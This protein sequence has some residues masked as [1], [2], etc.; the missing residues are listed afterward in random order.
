M[1]RRG[2]TLVVLVMLVA[3]C[4]ESS[5]APPQSAPE[6]TPAA[7]V[8]GGPNELGGDARPG[9]GL[10]LEGVP[11][12]VDSGTPLFIDPA[13]ILPSVPG[14]WQVAADS[15]PEPLCLGSRD[16]RGG[17]EFGRQ[18][19]TAAT[20]ADQTVVRA[21]S[22]ADA[23]AMFAEAIRA[24][25]ECSPGGDDLGHLDVG[26]ETRAFRT[27][28]GGTTVQFGIFRSRNTFATFVMAN[29]PGKEPE[30][31]FLATVILAMEPLA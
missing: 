18:Y 13:R 14:G 1:R 4:S 26:D 12:R 5:D 19:G 16:L 8:S 7:S 20:S 11:P 6:P 31:D 23:D 15:L 3:G 10:L 22:V 17:E 29:P 30:E 2:E 25:E 24:V 21:K 28:S 27:S 9:P